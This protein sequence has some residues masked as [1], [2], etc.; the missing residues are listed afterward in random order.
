MRVSIIQDVF[1]P[2]LGK[3][4]WQVKQGYASF[5]TFEFGEPHLHIQEP[6]KATKQATEKVRRNAARRRIF[7]HGDWHLWIYICDWRFFFKGEEIANHTS[8][9]KVVKK[10]ILELDGQ[11]LTSVT[12]KQSYV[13]IFEFDLGGKIEISP[14][15]KDYEKTSQLWFLY[16]PSGNVFTLRADGK[17]SRAQED[18]EDKWKPL[19][20]SKSKVVVK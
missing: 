13:S 16:E 12:I 19:V 5:V 15:H 9:R 14:N 6:R 18:E 11:A 17:Y 10:A 4:C 3:P 2:I 8:S 7:V 1:R 20:I